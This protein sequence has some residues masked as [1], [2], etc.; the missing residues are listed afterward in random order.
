MQCP[1]CGNTDLLPKFK[2]CPECGSPLSHAQNVPRKIEHGEHG[3]ETTLLQQSAASTSNYG[4]LGLDNRSI[5][6]ENQQQNVLTEE[7]KQPDSPTGPHSGPVTQCNTTGSHPRPAPQSNTI[8]PYPGPAPEPNTT[9]S[10][11]GLVPQSNI[12]DPYPGPVPQPDTTGSHPGLVQQVHQSNTTGPHPGLVPQS[13]TT[14]P[15]PGPVQ[16]SNTTGP[17]PGLV[18]QSNTTGP[19]PGP[20]QQS[21]ITGPHLGL[22]PHSNTT[23][24]HP[25]PL[26]Q[27]NTTGPHPGLVPQSNTT[28]SYP[29]PVQQSNTTGPHPGLVPQSNTT[30]SYPGPVQQSNT[31]GPHP[32]LVPQSNTTGPHP[33]PVQQSNTNGLHPGLSLQSNT[34]GPHPGPVQQSNTTGPHPGLVPQSNTTGPH[35]GPVQQSN[36]TDPHPGPVSQSYTTSPYPGSIPQSNVTDPYHGPRPESTTTGPHHGLLS[37]PDK[38]YGSVTVHARHDET[39]NEERTCLSE[40]EQRPE[41][42]PSTPS[43]PT[44]SGAVDSKGT[45]EAGTISGPET[46]TEE[47]AQSAIN[48]RH[49]E[50]TPSSLSHQGP[51]NAAEFKGAALP[52]TANETTGGQKDLSDAVSSTTPPLEGQREP[53]VNQDLNGGNTTSDTVVVD[54]E[55]VRDPAVLEVSESPNPPEVGD[56]YSAGQETTSRELSEKERNAS[57]CAS[58]TTMASTEPQQKTP[59]TQVRLGSSSEIKDSKTDTQDLGKQSS[60][61]VTRQAA[62]RGNQ[63][64]SNASPSS[65]SGRKAETVSE[66]SLGSA[67]N[68][69]GDKASKEGR[70]DAGGTWYRKSDTP[71]E[72]TLGGQKGNKKKGGKG[73]SN[74]GHE[75][76]TTQPPPSLQQVKPEAGVTVVFHVLL[77]SNFKTTEESFFIR[78]HGVDL[79]D[80]RQSCVDMRTVEIDESQEKDKLPL[81]RGQFTLSLDR[82]RKGTFYKYVVVK[83]GTVH[84]EEL[85]EFP[86]KYSCDGVVNR[87]LNIPGN[88]IEPGGK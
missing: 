67:V 44:H 42:A 16:Q 12:T 38:N 79:G 51:E 86:P 52:N 39:P 85:P 26:Q 48:N 77:S 9:G 87:S 30:G 60:G 46:P 54:A 70:K 83:K 27:S 78:A 61:P 58:R 82:A 21:N 17:H 20:V 57:E 63:N 23:G 2:C 45:V 25:G 18:L 32:G 10:H 33:G 47:R 71:I 66:H 11:P 14:G 49:P 6:G 3:V 7:R 29:G 53:I 72:E 13:N 64:Q 74:A 69:D 40:N 56:M 36:T 73:K 41:C 81:F 1:S 80:F 19:H 37:Q 55:A 88:Y 59:E 68:N 35:P 5:Q 50:C 62:N 84:W 15:H 28:G 76:S 43:D 31:T 34:T 8:D 4:D 22:K 75:A 24:S 65:A